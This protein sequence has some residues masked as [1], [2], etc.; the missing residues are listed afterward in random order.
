MNKEKIKMMQLLDRL[1][2]LITTATLIDTTNN[3]ID[4]KYYVKKEFISL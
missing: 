3:K 2:R 1:L 4:K